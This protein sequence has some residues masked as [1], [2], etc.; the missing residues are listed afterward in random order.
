MRQ[1][2]DSCMQCSLM[3]QTACMHKSGQNPGV[4]YRVPMQVLFKHCFQHLSRMVDAHLRELPE[5]VDR[6]V[7]Q[8]KA[9][10]DTIG[11]VSAGHVPDLWA[12]LVA[13]AVAVQVV[14]VSHVNGI[15]KHAPVVASKLDLT[16][17]MQLMSTLEWRRKFWK[18][19][20]ANRVCK[21]IDKFKFS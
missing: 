6:L 17:S 12:L 20:R 9:S 2:T 18:R 14:D 21:N 3:G 13:K 1:Q 11:I 5:L 19:H 4:A 8:P 15:L 16:C 10:L 7:V